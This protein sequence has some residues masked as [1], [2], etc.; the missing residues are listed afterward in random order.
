V[1]VDAFDF[2]LPD[3]LIADRPASPRDAARLLVVGRERLEDRTVRDL[4]SLLRPGDLVVF[5]DTRVLPARL[6]GIRRRAEAEAKIELLLHLR[7]GARTWRAFAR[8]AKRLRAGDRIAFGDAGAEVV[9]RGEEGEVEVRFDAD[10]LPLLERH[11]EIPLPPYIV[12]KRAPDARDRA[13]YQTIFAREAGAVAAPTAGLHFTPALLSGLRE[14]GVETRFVTLHVG[15]GTFLPVKP[16]DTDAH[17]MHAEIGH[18]DEATAKAVN[19]TKARGGRVIAV[20]TTVARLLESAVDA[21][22]NVAPFR[23]ETRLFITPGFRFRATDLLWSNFHLPRST[24]FMLVSAFVGL[25]R[26]RAAYA[27]AIAARYRFYSYGDACLFFPA[28]A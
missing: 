18:V 19:E 22:G 3:D 23:G 10:P 4:P 27:H 1:R 28:A 2:D 21:A 12:A 16:D 14:A 7:T 9:E 8:P 24:L 17:R 15:A 6:F 11:G 20:G 5:N 13:D 26:A 25:E